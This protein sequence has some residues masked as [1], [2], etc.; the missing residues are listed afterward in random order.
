MSVATSLIALLSPTEINNDIVT[1]RQ[2]VL[3]QQYNKVFAFTFV[4]TLMRIF[5]IKD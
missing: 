5:I 3:M 1:V 2:K 4:L